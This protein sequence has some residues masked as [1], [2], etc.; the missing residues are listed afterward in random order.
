MRFLN[1]LF[2][3]IDSSKSDGEISV[4]FK[5]DGSHDIFK[6]HFPDKPVVPGACVVQLIRE[7]LCEN[8]QTVKLDTSKVI[9]FLQPLIPTD[10]LVYELLI[11]WKEE[12]SK[13]L[14]TGQIKV[15]KQALFKY[16]GI[17][18]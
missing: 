17:Y 2:Q 13:I 9:K 4:N 3:V 8:V 16:K 1:N 5:L 7:V 10:N 15:E 12:D 18:S 6:G 11:T 14:V